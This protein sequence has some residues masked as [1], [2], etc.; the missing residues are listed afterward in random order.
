M[1]FKT[2]SQLLSTDLM[3]DHEVSF[4]NERSFLWSDF[5]SDVANL[6]CQIIKS[7]AENWALCCKNSYNFAVGFFAIIYS[8][9]NL[10]LPG[11]HHHS[12]L[13]ELSI[14]FDLIL[15]DEIL[16]ENFH[17][18]SVYFSKLKTIE[19]KTISDFYFY[20]LDLEKIV[21]TLFTSGS[22]GTP[23]KITKTLEMLNTEIMTLE[24]LWGK[25]LGKAKIQSTVSHQHIYG[26]LFRMLWPLS[27]ARSFANEDLVYPENVISHSSVDS[28]L[29]SS[30]AILKRLDFKGETY[31]YKAVFSSGGPLPFDAAKKSLELFGTYPNEIFG[32]TE[33]GGIGY[34]KQTSKTEP[35]TLFDTL[36]ANVSKDGTLKILSPWIDQNNWY[37]TTDI[38]EL[39]DHKHFMLKGRVDRIVKIEEKR[40]SLSNVETKLNR[41]PLYRYKCCDSYRA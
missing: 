37:Q 7:P 15:H 26:L 33:T 39:I 3:E 16:N 31:P 20:D 13:N 30:P 22:T 32:S 38:C 11:S 29:I 2:L 34:R 36:K 9:K 5:K 27:T 21:L 40:V 12:I 10:I 35:F 24:D 6:S 25:S 19:P 8:N 18:K 23:Q 4:S 1:S 17:K 41:L 14:N 28:V